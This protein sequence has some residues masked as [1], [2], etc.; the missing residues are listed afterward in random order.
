MSD[1]ESNIIVENYGESNF[2][3]RLSWRD[4]WKIVELRVLAETL[5]KCCGEGCSQRR[6]G[7]VSL[8]W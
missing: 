5:G 7:F 4:G 2:P 8:L 3:E 1:K 6:Y